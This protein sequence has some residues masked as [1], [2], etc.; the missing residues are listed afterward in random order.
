[1]HSIVQLMRARA[2]ADEQRGIVRGRRVS[3]KR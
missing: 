1:M 3:S 2:L